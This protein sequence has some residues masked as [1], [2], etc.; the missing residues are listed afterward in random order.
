MGEGA[1]FVNFLIAFP[2]GDDSSKG[3]EATKPRL[4]TFRRAAT[5]GRG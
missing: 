4:I 3:D 5:A 2:P 1:S